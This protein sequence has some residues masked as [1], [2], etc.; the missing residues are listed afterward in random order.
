MTSNEEANR[1]PDFW[2]YE[3][4]VN[5]IP[6]V[7]KKAIIEW[8]K[9]QD[10]PIPQERHNEWKEQG[11]FTKGLAVMLGVEEDEIF[12]ILPKIFEIESACW[13]CCGKSKRV[14]DMHP[15]LEVMT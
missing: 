14:S 5:V 7:N 10:N 4:V 12:E 15:V 6:A 11:K 9:Y 8:K 1:H 2:R 13:V 3:I